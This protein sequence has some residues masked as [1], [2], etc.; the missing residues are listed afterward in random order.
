MNRQL[1]RLRFPRAVWQ[2]MAVLG[3]IVLLSACGQTGPL[4]LP[5]PAHATAPAQAASAA[6]R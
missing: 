5:T 3:V 2:A 6:S 4:Y 1:N